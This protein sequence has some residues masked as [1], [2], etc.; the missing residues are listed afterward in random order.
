MPD[1]PAA[2][3]QKGTDAPRN[4]EAYSSDDCSELGRELGRESVRALDAKGAGVLVH[5]PALHAVIPRP[6]SV[7]RP[8]WSPEQ[9]AAFLRYSRHW[10]GI[11]SR[12]LADADHLPGR[13]PAMLRSA[14]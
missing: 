10:V 1:R 7:E 13:S 14:T 8:C 9:A 3:R 4:A 12:S 6:P 11:N 2:L 5:N